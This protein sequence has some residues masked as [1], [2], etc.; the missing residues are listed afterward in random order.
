MS[1]PSTMNWLEKRLEPKGTVRKLL[2]SSKL[3]MLM[4]SIEWLVVRK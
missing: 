4:A 3:E 2:Q 1:V